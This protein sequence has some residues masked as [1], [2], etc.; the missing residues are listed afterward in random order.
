MQNKG[1][2]AVLALV[3]VGAAAWVATNSFW[4][5][6]SQEAVRQQFEWGFVDRGVNT[7]ISA[8]QTAVQLRIAGVDVPLGTFTG[9]CFEIEGSS[10]ELLS[11]E[12]SGAICWWA[13]GGT[14][15]GVFEEEGQ[16]VLKQGEIEEGTAEGGG[17]RGN[18]KPLV[19]TQ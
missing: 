14:E 13:G 6:P 19:R 18:F 10:W 9:T 8:P 15:I 17:F 4:R 2:L 5:A 11:G 3:L 16:L 1:V 7:E 12:L